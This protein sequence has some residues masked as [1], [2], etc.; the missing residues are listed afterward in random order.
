MLRF[1]WRLPTGGERAPASRAH[2]TSVRQSGLPDLEAQVPFALAAEACGIDSLLIDFGW[3]KPDPILLA[4]ALGLATTKVRFIIAHRSGLMGPVTFVQQLNTLSAM[5]GDRFSLNIVAGHSPDEQRGYG[6]FLGHD[7]RYARTDEYLLICRALWADARDVTF[8]GKH[9]R[10]EH[11]RLNTPFISAQR[12]FPETYIAGN[13]P[14]ARSLSLTRGSCWMRLADTPD[15]VAADARQV[16]AGGGELGVRIQTVARRTHAEAVEAAQAL[17]ASAGKEFDD[18]GAERRFITRSDSVSMHAADALADR[19]WLTP[20]LWTG[21]V[22][23]HGAAAMALVGDPDE[24]ASALLEY[25]RAG[26]SQFIISGWPKLEEMQFFGEH[27]LP[28]VRA[29]EAA[30]EGRWPQHGAGAGA[31]PAEPTTEPAGR[32]PSPS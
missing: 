28:R 9:Y 20:C 29:R 18:Q 12:A 23:T 14:P 21:L 22:R 3:A 4:T 8:E 32:S 30:G 11:A 25:G 19:E 13:S 5:I 26:V 16:L 17:A 31:R 24:L 2:L 10:V 1:H 6:D 15:Q 27:V 7:D